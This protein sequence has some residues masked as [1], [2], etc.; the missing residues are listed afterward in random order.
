MKVEETIEEVKPNVDD[1][2]DDGLETE[3]ASAAIDDGKGNKMV[4][5]SSLVS[6]KKELRSSGK[7]MKELETRA[8]KA[9]EIEK[10]LT[11]AQPIIDAIVSDPKLLARAKQIAS[12]KPTNDRVEQ[13][14][15]DED[16]DAAALAETMELYTKEGQLD[17]VKA[18]KVLE[19]QDRRSGRTAQEAVRPFAGMAL[20]QKAEANLSRIMAETDDDGVPWATRESIQEVAKLLP[21]NLL[22]DPQVGQLVL[23]SAIGIDKQKKRTPK[24]PD[25]PIYMESSSGRRNADAVVSSEEKR[26]GS[27]VG[28]SEK[29]LAA[30]SKVLESTAPGKGVRLE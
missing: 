1:D 14:E 7:K 5:L 23:T 9:E 19:I 4:P 8:S 13:P 28:L 17:I 15:V 26:I 12:G 6:A 21:P 2:P 11:N 18:R 24:P 10:R 27:R 22:A 29:D 30:S 20:G 3:L 25:E 16:P